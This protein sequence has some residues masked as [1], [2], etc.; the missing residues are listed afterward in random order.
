ML[1]RES[2]LEI[3]WSLF[4]DAYALHH[5]ADC[6]KSIDNICM[7]GENVDHPFRRSPCSRRSHYRLHP[8]DCFYSVCLSVCQLPIPLLPC[9]HV[10]DSRKPKIDLQIAHAVTMSRALSHI[11]QHIVVRLFVTSA[12]MSADVN[13]LLLCCCAHFYGWFRGELPCKLKL[14]GFSGEEV[15]DVIKFSS[16]GCSGG[17]WCWVNEAAMCWL[18]QR[19][20]QRDKLV[21]LKLHK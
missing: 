13:E 2:A 12:L 10:P 20:Q 6:F 11:S 21:S 9:L 17:V 14:M 8:V 19:L 15:R 3:Q 5:V 16:T 7:N 1:R 18:C 4:F